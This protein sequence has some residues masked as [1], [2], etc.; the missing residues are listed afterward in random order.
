MP[1]LSSFAGTDPSQLFALL[2]SQQ[3]QNLGASQWNALRDAA[4][5]AQNSRGGPQPWQGTY[6]AQQPQQQTPVTLGTG[7][8][9]NVPIDQGVLSQLLLGARGTTQPQWH[10]SNAGNDFGR[11]DL[12]QNA[13]P[14]PQLDTPQQRM[15]WLQTQPQ[16]RNATGPQ[17]SGYYEQTFGIDPYSDAVRDQKN[18]E[19]AVKMQQ[20]QMGLQKDRQGLSQSSQIFP[21]TL[22]DA[23]Q[24]NAQAAAMNPIDLQKAQLSNYMDA[25]HTFDP[26]ATPEMIKTTYNDPAHPNQFEIPGSYEADPLQPGKFIQKPSR[27]VWAQPQDVQ[28]LLASSPPGMSS[29]LSSDQ[30]AARRDA[31][32]SRIAWLTAKKN[33]GRGYALPT[34]GVAIGAGGGVQP[35][36]S[37]PFAAERSLAQTPKPIDMNL[38]RF[39]QSAQAPSLTRNY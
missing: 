6:Y 34:Q 35:V 27:L 15:S 24:K 20:D 22:S 32:A 38:M 7:E 10:E 8:R 19:A 13:Q 28:S 12:A 26:Q 16:L 36:S 33:S 18:K 29:Q 23:Q 4:D 31:V 9:Q 2:G 5:Y 30:N 11:N 39:L 14:A 37:D 3:G 17:L 25:A 21:F 1:P